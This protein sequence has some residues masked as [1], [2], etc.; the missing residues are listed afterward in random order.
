MPQQDVGSSPIKR[1]LQD[2]QGRRGQ[3]SW[4]YDPRHIR[5]KCRS[6]PVIAYL[7]VL[8]YLIIR[9]YTISNPVRY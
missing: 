9:G 3:Y 1:M 5:N 8:L 7:D 4:R 6:L 2:V